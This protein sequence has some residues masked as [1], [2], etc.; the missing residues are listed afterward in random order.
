MSNYKLYYQIIIYYRNY[1][2]KRGRWRSTAYVGMVWC[3]VFLFCHL[4]P[5]NYKSRRLLKNISLQKSM[6]S[7]EVIDFGSLISRA[8]N[9]ER[10]CN[11]YI[12]YMQYTTLQW[13]F[14]LVEYL[15]G[16]QN[17]S[18][19]RCDLKSKHKWNDFEMTLQ[20]KSK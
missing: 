8:F 4:Y 14:H 13:I 19:L 12:V 18:L 16:V 7:Y 17:W 3:S 9:N 5:N 2:F 6:F 10:T 15:S 1:Q 11:Y 20:F